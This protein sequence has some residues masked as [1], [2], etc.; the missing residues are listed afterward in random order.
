MARK[1]GQRRRGQ[2]AGTSAPTILRD[3]ARRFVTR[4]TATNISETG[5]F[6]MVRAQPDLPREGEVFVEIALP[7]G[8]GRDAIRRTAVYCCRIVRTQQ[9]GQLVGL[10]MEFVQKLA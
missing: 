2:R 8:K 3:S 1:V 5:V 10:G 6:L 7:E 4:C 9:I